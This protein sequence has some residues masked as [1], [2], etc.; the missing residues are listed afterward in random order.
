MSEKLRNEVRHL[1][2]DLELYNKGYTNRLA[3]EINENPK[4]I[5]MA[6]TGN[7]SGPASIE[8]LRKLKKALEQM[9]RC[10]AASIY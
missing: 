8:I 3:N 4:S 7:R 5:S 2:I 9:Q 1:L 10:D 6:V